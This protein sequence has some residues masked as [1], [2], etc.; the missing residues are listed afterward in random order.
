MRA[1]VVL[2]AGVAGLLRRAHAHEPALAQRPKATVL[3]VADAA[4]RRVDL[5]AG[6]MPGMSEDDT[7]WYAKLDFLVPGIFVCITVLGVGVIAFEAYERWCGRRVETEVPEPSAAAQQQTLEIT[8]IFSG[9]PG[10]LSPYYRDEVRGRSYVLVV[11]LL[12]LIALFLKFVY[13][14]WQLEFWNLFQ[15]D[16]RAATALDRFLHLMGIFSLLLVCF[17]LAD[18][19]SQYIRLLLYIDWRQYMTDRLLDRWLANHAYYGMQLQTGPGKVD[20]PDQRVQED[21]GLFIDHAI[22]IIWEFLSSLGHLVVFLPLLLA[23]APSTAFG[24]VYLPGWLVYLALLYSLLG[25]LV[26]HCIDIC[27]KD[28]RQG[29]EVCLTQLV[30]DATDVVAAAIN[31]VNVCVAVAIAT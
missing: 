24:V 25:S 23:Y 12:G 27:V 28:V 13:N 19:Y 17:V 31:T 1:L 20:N 8:K 16:H 5:A 14:S 18:V 9:I 26:A 2:A 22:N 7:P 30:C 3:A 15:S 6:Q 21:V 29:T 11:L 4:A 10:L